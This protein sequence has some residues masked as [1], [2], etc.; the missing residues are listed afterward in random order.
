MVGKRITIG[1]EGWKK[2]RIH[3]DGGVRELRVNYRN[4]TG[5]FFCFHFCF[6][7]S[8]NIELCVSVSVFITVYAS[9]NMS[10]SGEHHR[11]GLRRYKIH[12]WKPCL[13]TVRKP[14]S[15]FQTG[16]QLNSSDV[17]IGCSPCFQL[18]KDDAALGGGKPPLQ[19]GSEGQSH[20]SHHKALPSFFTHS[21]PILGSEDVHR[22]GVWCQR[23]S[24]SRV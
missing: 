23:L 17:Q 5:V 4:K 24:L 2:K 20:G 13:P 21:P 15:S 18:L 7:L 3:E 16:S 6:A 12:S 14:P 19:Q 22:C 11:V 10:F 9:K 1:R 8:T